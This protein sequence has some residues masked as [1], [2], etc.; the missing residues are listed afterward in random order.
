[1]D[2]QDGQNPGVDVNNSIM[3]TGVDFF[4]TTNNN[5]THWQHWTRAC[6]VARSLI[7]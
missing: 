3:L 4:L 5:N 7:T 1:M 2:P 6:V